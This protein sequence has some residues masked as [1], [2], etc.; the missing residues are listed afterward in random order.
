L[1]LP[2]PG[3][4]SRGGDEAV[5]IVLSYSKVR[6]WDNCRKRYQF[7][8]MKRVPGKP[9]KYFVLGNAVHAAISGYLALPL[10]EREQADIKLM[11][12]REWVKDS[13]GRKGFASREEEGEFGKRALGMLDNFLEDSSSREE[14]LALEEWLE[15]DLG[16]EVLLNGK[17]DRIDR[18]DGS[19]HITDLKTGQSTPTPE[20]LAAEV[21]PVLNK[22]L[23]ER[24]RGERVGGV[25]FYYLER[26]EKLTV[27]VD[28]R[29]VEEAEARLKHVAR[30]IGTESRFEA[31]PNLFCG[32]CDYL[33]RCVE[34]REHLR[35]K[36]EAAEDGIA[37][38]P[39]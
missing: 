10:T 5:M 24:A 17:I 15:A 12:K 3:A 11:L 29:A 33:D 18:R 21:Q 1:R 39:F 30:Q 37:A 34:G 6:T 25:T 13:R 19:L 36:E 22:L 7:Q 2:R 16:D 26:D 35:S 8:Y 14:P 28:D 23:V 31:S 4:D 27:S 20:Q 38:L 32:W 9:N